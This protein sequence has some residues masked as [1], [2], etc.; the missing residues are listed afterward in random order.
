[1]ADRR[2]F[3]PEAWGELRKLVLEESPV[4]VVNGTAGVGKSWLVADL[5]RELVESGAMQQALVVPVAG[6]VEGWGEAL[7]AAAGGGAPQELPAF[8][9]WLREPA[10]IAFDTVVAPADAIA[11]IRG[12]RELVPSCRVLL[13]SRRDVHDAEIQRFEVSPLAVPEG[14]T[15]VGPAAKYFIERLR[16]LGIAVS[17]EVA[18]A[19]IVRLLDGLPLAM[20]LAAPRLRIMRPPVLLHRL[21]GS[22]SLLR[23]ETSSFDD[24]LEQSWGV[25]GEEDRRALVALSVVA[26]PFSLASAEAVIAR[27]TVARLESLRN[28]GWLRQRDDGLELLGG[29]ANFAQRKATDTE[30]VTA[31]TRLAASLVARRDGEARRQ[32]AQV[33]A[34]AASRSRLDRRQAEAVLALAAADQA[35]GPLLDDGLEETT[36][37]GAEVVDAVLAASQGSGA[38]PHLWGKAWRARAAAA[39]RRAAWDD[40]KRALGHAATMAESRRDIGEEAEVSL[41]WARLELM[42]GDAERAATIGQAAR[43]RMAALRNRGGELAA[44]AVLAEASRLRGDAAN[45]VALWAR[46]VAQA[47]DRPAWADAA[48]LRGAWTLLD[49]GRHDEARA[50]LDAMSRERLVGAR[51]SLEAWLAHDAG[52]FATAEHAYRQAMPVAR[53]VAESMALVGW[54]LVRLAQGGSAEAAAA[55]RQAR[56]AAEAAG[57]GDW[58]RLAVALEQRADAGLPP[59][60]RAPRVAVAGGP[61][62][63]WVDQLAKAL[64]GGAEATG[65]L[66]RLA[67]RGGSQAWAADADTLVVHP[68]GRWFRP[69][70]GEAVSLVNRPVVARILAALVARRRT[71][72]ASASYADLV[73]AGWPGERMRADAGAHRVRVAVSTLRKLGLRTQLETADGGYR[74]DP[75]CPLVVQ[76]D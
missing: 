45:A 25:L 53:G 34:R 41:A 66:A 10:V 35:L 22:R 38:D 11:W 33:L 15:L 70:G 46:V 28:Q 29:L 19:E 30:I 17:D 42:R 6:G 76:P 74:L 9:R 64:E 37:L 59:T 36:P 8:F 47:G 51:R 44:L 56:E 1:M 39:T 72:R 40:A 7:M 68:E 24:T 21:R 3:R 5:C 31:E 12:W 58:G 14:D 57:R 60:L 4:I 23:G 75:A 55:F 69:P 48:R 32:A 62:G 49:L 65:I 20:D 61:D 71:P 63:S 26:S 13:V 54:G 67:A 18:L 2:C 43:E 52:D 27:E 50:W 73:E 16:L